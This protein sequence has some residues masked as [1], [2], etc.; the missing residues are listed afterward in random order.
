M[1]E[2]AVV[3]GV[4]GTI[5]SAFT[6]AWPAVLVAK[7]VAKATLQKKEALL[8]VGVVKALVFEAI[9]GYEGPTSSYFP[10]NPFG[11]DSDPLCVHFP[12]FVIGRP[13]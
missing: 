6:L 10:S 8:K 2:K 11:K 12:S 5:R 4:S 1:L 9:Y 7:T 3:G 13:L